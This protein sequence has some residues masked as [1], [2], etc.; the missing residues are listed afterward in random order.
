MFYGLEQKA[1][2][3][4]VGVGKKNR[5]TITAIFFPQNYKYVNVIK[6]S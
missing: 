6:I 3:S 4:L 5:T 1:Y 2:I